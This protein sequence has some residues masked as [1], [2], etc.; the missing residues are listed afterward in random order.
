[1]SEV[2]RL[3]EVDRWMRYAR[4]D[5]RAASLLAGNGGV[6]RAACFHAQQAAEKAIK[7]IFVFLQTDFP[8]V[9][10][11]NRLRN[12][13]PEGWPVKEN[14]PDLSGLSLWAVES[15]YPGD[16]CPKQPKKMREPPLSRP[17]RSTRRR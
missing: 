9:H 13:L 7:A 1:M 15:R 3:R 10:D 5:L 17:V 16:L 2:E 14:L 12:S 8:Y 6:P 4:E 11:L